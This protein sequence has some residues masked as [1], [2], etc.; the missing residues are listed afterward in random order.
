MSMPEDEGKSRD[1]RGLARKYPIEDFI[2]ALEEMDG[3]ATTAEVSEIVGC[4]SRTA[5]RTMDELRSDKEKPVSQR[6]V[7]QYS[8]WLLSTE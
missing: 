1:S 2:S 3:M 7:G 4:S 5:R 6:D 8:L